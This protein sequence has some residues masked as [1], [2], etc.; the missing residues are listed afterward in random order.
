MT[1]AADSVAF[2]IINKEYNKGNKKKNLKCS[3][4]KKV[5]QYS[6]KCDK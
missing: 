4:C 1:E 3:K 2:L 6:N 5:G